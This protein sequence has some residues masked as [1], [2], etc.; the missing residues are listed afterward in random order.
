MSRGEEYIVWRWLRRLDRLP[1]PQSNGPN[2]LWL[3]VD[4]H[5][6]NEF[7]RNSSAEELA[8]RA[9]KSYRCLDWVAR[10]TTIATIAF[11]LGRHSRRVELPRATKNT[12]WLDIYIFW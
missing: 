7:A 5:V 3:G 6:G 2:L 12:N 1:S 9:A 8:V 11:L 4:G 10:M